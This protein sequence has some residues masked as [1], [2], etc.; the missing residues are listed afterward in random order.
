MKKI[1]LLILLFVF[2]LSH[3]QTKQQRQKITSTYN[4][5]KLV[6]LSEKL[7]SKQKLEKENALKLA[8][9][10]NWK[11]EYVKDGVYY[12]LQRVSS[13]GKPIYY[14]T[15]NVNAAKSTRANHLHNG[16]TL[17]LNIEGQNMTAYV[18]DGGVA[19]EGHQ[20][21][22]G[23]GGNNR[24]TAAEN[25]NLS[26]HAGHVMG[27]IIASGHI[28]SAKGMAPKASGIGYKWDSD[29]SEVIDETLNGMLLSNHS[30]GPGIESV[31]DWGFGAY[32]SEA[33]DWDQILYNAPYYMMVV[34]AGNDGNVNN[35]NGDPLE[36]NQFF[37]KLYSHSTC[38]NNMVIA[39][40]ND[41]NVQSDGTL[42]SV[43]INSTSSEGP[44]DDLR[45]KPDLTGNG[46]LVYSC[47]TTSNNSYGSFTGTS[48]ASPNVM[49]SLLLLQQHY[50]NINGTFM[51][52]STL[53]GL[54]LHTANDS[55]SAGP[56]AVWGWGL[57]NTKAAAKAI[58]ENGFQ[59]VVVEKTLNDGE[60][61]SI[62]VKS[63]GTH[64][65]LASISWT[66]VP[67]TP[68][69]GTTNDPTPVLV[70]DLDVRVNNGTDYMPW[71]LTSI[72]S[73]TKAD[74]IVDPF[75]RVDVS[76]ASGYYTITVTHKGNLSS[77]KQDFA[78]VI[79]GLESDF[80]FNAVNDNVAQC[81]PNNAEFDFTFETLSGTTDS[82]TFSATN[83]PSGANVAFSPNPI[84][85]DGTVHMTV[86]N[87]SSV[88]PGE[89]TIDISATNANETETKSV[90]LS[91]YSPNFAIP[92]LVSPLDNANNLPFSFDL[93]WEED[94][95]SQTHQ[96]QIATDAAFTNIVLTD[97]VATNFYHAFDLEDATTYYWRVK[98]INICSSGAFS[99]VHQFTTAACVTYSYTGSPLVIP[100]RPNKL[101]VPFDVTEGFSI[102]DVNVYLEIMHDD[103]STLLLTLKHPD[104]T[105]MYLETPN[106]DCSD[107]QNM[108][109]GFNDAEANMSSCGDESTTYA[110]FGNFKPQFPLSKFNDLSATGT[111]I[112]EIRDLTN[113]GPTGTL[114]NYSL[115]LCEHNYVSVED[116]SNFDDFNL[117]PNP[118][119][120]NINISFNSNTNNNV[121][122]DLYD[123]SG[124][125]INQKIYN[126]AAE[127]FNENINFGN[128]SEG[129][130]LVKVING[131]KN[132]TRKVIIK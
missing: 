49:G 107:T 15:F 124:R 28:A 66:D 64:P 96:I 29:M 45:I 110:F 21:Y 84:N 85:T 81:A 120:G 7:A 39:N 23:A 106:S 13:E 11:V 1:L 3:A 35:E 75:E 30:Y 46:T 37:D 33:S 8:K 59:S 70:N 69:T 98:P 42:N 80:T 62:T 14:R 41:A 12:D 55:G 19:R 103:V 95:N 38:K 91:V 78:L 130:Y 22:D 57:M 60:S 94:F 104:G 82:T 17:G 131:N 92:N 40:A 32:S 128:L 101:Q 89:Y 44:T 48:M 24:F 100:D 34:A 86:S 26:D 102:K 112:L 68:N 119:N 54:A 118:S 47:T 87:L 65:L 108:K 67:G 53:K 58:S 114:V 51:R 93:T 56:D 111:W 31:P 77:G 99:S 88:T 5:N 109:I 129:I 132:S 25:T 83:L 122:I 20:E 43:Y 36:G 61:Y 116:F 115:N 27:T 90:V 113:G 63:D 71:K 123:I 52:S 127:N 97:T 10:K 4:I 2:S 125:L 126:N 72:T 117:W 76:G 105:R 18:W 50:N 16:G 121:V 9:I 6:N 74:N 73:N 79:T